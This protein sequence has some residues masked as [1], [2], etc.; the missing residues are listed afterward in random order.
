M[1]VDWRLSSFF[2]EVETWTRDRGGLRSSDG[3]SLVPPT[4]KV[5]PSG[6]FFFFHSSEYPGVRKG[7][8]SECV[9]LWLRRVVQSLNGPVDPADSVVLFRR[10]RPKRKRF[11][12]KVCISR[13]RLARLLS[14]SEG[15]NFRVVLVWHVQWDWARVWL[16]TFTSVSVSSGFGDGDNWPS[17]EVWLFTL[18]F[19]LLNVKQLPYNYLSPLPFLSAIFFCSWRRE[20]F[21]RRVRGPG[22]SLFPVCCSW[23]RR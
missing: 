2:L 22:I 1:G 9:L 21:N 15:H 5:S 10:V 4:T 7:K 16:R 18:P 6:S 13:S 20:Y 19:P 23:F 8:W 14:F 11:G 12:E 3:S 17:G